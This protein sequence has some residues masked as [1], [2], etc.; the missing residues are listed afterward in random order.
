LIIIE[1]E[2]VIITIKEGKLIIKIIKDFSF[3]KEYYHFIACRIYF[4]NFINWD[5]INMLSISQQ[6]IC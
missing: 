2:S 1:N 4:V 3:Y 6:T 5:I